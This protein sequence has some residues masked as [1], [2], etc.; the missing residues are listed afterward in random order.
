MTSIREKILQVAPLQLSVLIEGPTGSGKELVAKGLHS[1]SGRMGGFVPVNVCALA[2]TMFDD[3]LFGHVRGAFTGAARDHAGYLSEAH[4]GT[5]FLDEIASMPLFAQAKLL[6]AIETREFRPIGARADFKSEFRMVS[7]TNVPL[8]V[9]TGQ[10]TFR[11]DLKFRLTG[12]VIRL[13][14]LDAHVE[15]V[16]ELARHF[17][18][19]I[20]QAHGKQIEFSEGALTVLENRSWPGNIRELRHVVERVVAMSQGS[21]VGRNEITSLLADESTNSLSPDQEF[22]K[23]RL[24]ALLEESRWDVKRVAE[25]LDLHRGS[26]YRRMKHLGIQSPLSRRTLET[27][28][29]ASRAIRVRQSATEC[30]SVGLGKSE[31]FESS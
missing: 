1:A 24:Q 22:E 14:S 28:D 2:E 26:L 20:G 31:V 29:Q 11:E 21:R 16:P 6:R 7:A 3:A 4:R 13:P 5:I 15:D 8:S 25:L 17:A 27:Y 23:R 12:V 30:D 19:M 10:Q 9:L 18:S